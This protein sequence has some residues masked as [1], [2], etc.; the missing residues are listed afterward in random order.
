MPRS[1]ADFQTQRLQ[2]WEGVYCP[3]RRDAS[4]RLQYRQRSFFKESGSTP[5]AHKFF[6]ELPDSWCLGSSYTRETVSCVWSSAVDPAL[7][8]GELKNEVWEVAKVTDFD[9]NFAA[10][11]SSGPGASPKGRH[12]PSQHDSRCAVVNV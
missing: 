11:T 1:I 4:G 8:N 2:S 9:A 3:E 10:A 5:E 12:R 7:A 6:F